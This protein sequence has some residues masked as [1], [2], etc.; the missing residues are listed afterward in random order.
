MNKKILVRAY[1]ASNLGDDMFV[2]QLVNRYPNVEFL[3]F[4]YAAHKNA[5]EKFHNVKFVPQWLFNL[6]DRFYRF[7]KIRPVA[8][9]LCKIVFAVVHIGGSIFIE[10]K[11]WEE[12]NYK[13]P[14]AKRF[15]LGANFGPYRTERFLENVE[16]RISLAR[17]ICF[18]DTYSYGKFSHLENVRHAPDILFGYSNYPEVCEGDCLG[19]SVIDLCG[20]EG[21][22][23]MEGQY[24]DFLT[25]T[26]E[27]F[28]QRGIKT[29]LLVFCEREGDLRAAHKII[30]ML[31]PSRAEVCVYDQNVEDFLG[32]INSCRYMIATRFHAMVIGFAMKKRVFPIIYSEKQSNVLSDLNYSGFCWN[33]LDGV[34]CPIT[35][36]QLFDGMSEG[37]VDIDNVKMLSQSHFE[38]LDQYLKKEQPF[39]G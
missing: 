27:A 9:V 12:K 26:V 20:R 24:L 7:L 28:Y 33:L 36:E 37:I 2:Q 8:F 39:N 19:I 18:R 10:P 34:C 15:Y 13:L 38:K 32:I 4:S 14:K 21:L 1:L 35:P 3:I 6:D 11:Q 25:E 23:N 22:A 30:S 17:D 5:F 29:K 31:N 16:K